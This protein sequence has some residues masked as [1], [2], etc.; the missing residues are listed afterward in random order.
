MLSF[1]ILLQLLIVCT[2]LYVFFI[3]IKKLMQRVDIHVF[4]GSRNRFYEMAYLKQNKEAGAGFDVLL[5][6]DRKSVV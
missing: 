4:D 6:A 3:I 2:V 1:D 5:T